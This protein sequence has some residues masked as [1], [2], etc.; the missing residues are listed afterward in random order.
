MYLTETC[1]ADSAFHRMLL[2][3]PVSI[4]PKDTVFS[5]TQLYSGTWTD[6]LE[7]QNLLYL[8][9]SSFLSAGSPGCDRGSCDSVVSGKHFS[10]F[11]NHF[12]AA[13]SLAAP[14]FQPF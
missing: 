10:P 5:V 11:L 9:L 8:W 13:S 6:S 2:R 3:G 12:N 4:P 1:E 7:L 14:T